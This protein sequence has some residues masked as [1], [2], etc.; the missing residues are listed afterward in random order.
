MSKECLR[1]KGRRQE[2]QEE[3]RGKMVVGHTIDERPASIDMRE[4]FGHW[5]LDTVVSSRGASH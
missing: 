2:K 4:E 5:E 3:K 1:H